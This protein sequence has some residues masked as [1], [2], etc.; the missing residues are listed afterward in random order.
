M[1]ACSWPRYS[2]YGVSKESDTFFN[3]LNSN[4]HVDFPISRSLQFW[5]IPVNICAHMYADAK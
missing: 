3:K 4:E 2:S 5:L 1:Y